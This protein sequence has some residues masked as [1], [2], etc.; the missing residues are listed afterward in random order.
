MESQLRTEINQII[1]KLPESQ[2][3]SILEYLQQVEK[4][5]INDL[6]TANLVKK[7]FTEDSELL[8]KLAQ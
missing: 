4:A 1:L 3:K 7:I 2:L 5:N 8:K 6:E